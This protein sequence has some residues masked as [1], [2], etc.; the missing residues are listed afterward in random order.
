MIGRNG[1]GE[2]IHTAPRLDERK[3]PPTA[4]GPLRHAYVQCGCHVRTRYAL[5]KSYRCQKP[6]EGY[7]LSLQMRLYR[8]GNALSI[9]LCKYFAYYA[10]NATLRKSICE[11]RFHGNKT[12]YISIYICIRKVIRQTLP[13]DMARPRGHGGARHTLRLRLE[14]QAQVSGR[15]YFRIATGP[16]HRRQIQPFQFSRGRRF[17]GRAGLRAKRL[18]GGE[19]NPENKKPGERN[20]VRAG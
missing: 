17:T 19:L 7:C 15:R 18:A 9:I 12:I 3:A 11:G 10:K 16:H 13:T 2:S 1:G 20:A 6:A 14:P 8:R 5:G 4:G